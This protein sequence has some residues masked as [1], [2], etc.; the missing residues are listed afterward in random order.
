MLI[1]SRIVLINRAMLLLR[2]SLQYQIT[3][4]YSS[5][6][7]IFSNTDFLYNLSRIYINNCI[8]KQCIML[9]FKCKYFCLR[10][11][12]CFCFINVFVNCCF[13][14]ASGINIG[15]TQFVFSIRFYMWLWICM[16]MCMIM[17]CS[18][19]FFTLDL[20][21]QKEKTAETFAKCWMQI[22]LKL[23]DLMVLYN[24][25]LESLQVQTEQLQIR[26]AMAAQILS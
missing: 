24:L 23:L 20:G 8:P 21:A 26:I 22:V 7:A 1:N 18:V 3:I 2:D 11:C 4:I 5:L 25:F 19:T 15:I 13:E 10:V 17:C 16:C 14:L 9:V 6:N 12:F